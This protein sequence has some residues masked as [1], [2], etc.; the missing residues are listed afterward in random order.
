M[1][2]IVEYNN[3]LVCEL[4]FH[5]QSVGKFTGCRARIEAR[6]AMDDHHWAQPKEKKQDAA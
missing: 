5:N 4:F 2:K 6:Q 3:G 1:Y